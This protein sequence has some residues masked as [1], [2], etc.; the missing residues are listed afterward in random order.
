MIKISEKRNQKALF[1]NLEG[2]GDLVGERFHRAQRDGDF[3]RIATGAVVLG[4]LG[5]HD[6]NKKRKNWYL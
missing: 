6:L 3:G 2:V 4:E 5:N 1:L